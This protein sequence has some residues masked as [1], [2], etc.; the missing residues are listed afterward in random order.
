MTGYGAALS[1]TCMNISAAQ[2]RY[3]AIRNIVEHVIDAENGF[4]VRQ[5]VT[6]TWTLEQ[7][8]GLFPLGR[9]IQWRNAVRRWESMILDTESVL[10]GDWERRFHWAVLQGSTYVGY[11]AK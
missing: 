8:E 2:K 10:D 9:T 7:I 3:D 5:G 1:N 4:K 6:T 11:A